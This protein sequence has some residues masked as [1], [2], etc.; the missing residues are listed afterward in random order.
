[1]ENPENS[2]NFLDNLR[3]RWELALGLGTAATVAAGAAGVAAHKRRKAKQPVYPE[4]SLAD[5][6]RW[7]SQLAV[8]RSTSSLPTDLKKDGQTALAELNGMAFLLLDHKELSLQNWRYLS[9]IP[10]E[11]FDSLLKA[12]R[13]KELVGYKIIRTEDSESIERHFVPEPALV[14]GSAH[15]EHAPMLA[16]LLEAREQT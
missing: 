13:G 16:E 15:R 11:R 9:G 12:L 3:T 6:R 10:S 1:M 2:R 4:G 5:E 14:W 8:L 7:V